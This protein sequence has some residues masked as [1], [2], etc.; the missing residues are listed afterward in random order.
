[1]AAKHNNIPRADAEFDVFLRNLLMYVGM[2]C[3]STPPVWT[4]IPPAARNALGEHYAA[5]HAAYELTLHPH[6]RPQTAE[7]NR[8]HKAA[9]RAARD[10]INIYLR[11]HPDVT[12]EDKRNMGLTVPDTTRTPVE[13]PDEGPVFLIVQLGP[14]LVGINYQ[15]GQGRKGSKPDG[16]KGAR[17]YYGVFDGPPEDMVFPKSVWATRCPHV[18]SFRETDRGKRAWFALKWETGRGGEKGESGWSELVSEI[19]P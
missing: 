9:D 11:Y 14:R 3:D 13:A 2:K 16:I 1:M 19:I 8:L 6:T 15:Y 12:E 17:I 5:W 7:K 18:I 4:H 10:F